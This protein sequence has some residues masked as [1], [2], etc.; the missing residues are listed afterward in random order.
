MSLTDALLQG[1]DM[2]STQIGVLTRFRQERTAMIADIES[3]F[4]QLRVCLDDSD[5]LLLKYYCHCCYCVSCG[6]LVTISPPEEYQMTVHLYGTVSSPSCTNIRGQ[7]SKIQ[8][9]GNQYSQ[10]KLLRRSLSETCT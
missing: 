10:K 7:L 2:T 8:F 5:V 9:R 3:M 1:P 6:G 4:H